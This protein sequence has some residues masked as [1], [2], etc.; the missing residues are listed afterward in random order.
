MIRVLLDNDVAGFQTL[1]VGAVEK[2]GWGEYELIELITLESVG[3]GRAT[4]DRAI[5]RHCQ[6]NGLILLTA[7][8]NQRARIRSN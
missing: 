3:L 6:L 1:L 4:S 8:R 7:N 2:T 5:W